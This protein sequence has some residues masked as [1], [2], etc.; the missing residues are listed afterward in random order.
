MQSLICQTSQHVQQYSLCCIYHFF[1]ERPTFAIC[2]RP[3]VCLSVSGGCNF[4]Q[5]FYGIWYLGIDIRRKFYG[6]RP[7]EPLHQ[8]S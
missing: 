4:R 6:D 8:E 1:S 3:S 7:R 2:C 5:Y